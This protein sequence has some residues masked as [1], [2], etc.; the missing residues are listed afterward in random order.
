MKVAGPATTGADREFTCKMGFRAGRESPGLFVAHM[1]PVDRLETPQR[2]RE[3]VQG[4]ADH[5]INPPDTGLLKGFRKEI[6]GGS[7]HDIS[8]KALGSDSVQAS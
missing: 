4:I 5:A 1:D 7:G 6:G 2:V 3:S 8:P